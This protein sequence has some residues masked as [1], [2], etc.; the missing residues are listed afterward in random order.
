MADS[1]CLFIRHARPEID[2][3]LPAGQWPLSAEGQQQTLALAQ[4]LTT[5]GLTHIITSTE[6][7]AIETGRIIATQLG[8]PLLTAPNLHEHDRTDVPFQSETQF[9]QAIRDLF[10][11]PDQ[12]IFGRETANQALTRFSQAVK[13]LLAMFPAG[14]IAIVAHGTVISLYVAACSGRDGYTLWQSLQQP[15]TVWFNRE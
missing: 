8:L 11:Y 1:F 13:E 4:Q 2:P 3:Q 14:K 12:L 15:D 10:A 5:V 9:Q 7:K 6:Q